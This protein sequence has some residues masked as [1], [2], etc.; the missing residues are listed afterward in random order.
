M[1][2]ISRFF[3]FFYSLSMVSNTF[4]H[5]PVMDMAP[6]W[7]NGYGFQIRNE[8]FFS[9]ILLKKDSEIPT[10]IPVKKLIN[11]TWI[12]GIYTFKRWIR[13][14]FKLP[15]I[16]QNKITEANGSPLKKTSSGIG[17]LI[18][19]LPLKLYKNLE[20]STQNLAFTPSIRLPTGSTKGDLPVSNGST[21]FGFSFSRSIES[22][23]IYQLYDVFY[24]I[25]NNGK[26]GDLEG[27]EIG[28]DIN[29]GYHPYHDNESNKGVFVMLDVL[30]RYKEKGLYL[31]NI[32]GGL[33]LYS[34]PI[35]V[36]YKENIM[37]RSS[38]NLPIYE[39]LNGQQF[40]RGTLFN[41]GIGLVF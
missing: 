9:N 33:G 20:A 28:F 23:K 16:K 7:E 24:W 6:R 27:N 2:I 14:S 41:L 38:F 22:E 11:K 12:E 8:S 35:L 25:N 19:G 17:D 4:A 18:I 30:G 3:L 37:F 1:K 10:S 26:N 36:L 13:L 29:W 5:Q 21:D 15:W 32:T 39:N 34:G 31:K 40:S